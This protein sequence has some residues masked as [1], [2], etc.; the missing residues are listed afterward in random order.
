MQ[1]GSIIHSISIA[2]ITNPG[3]GGTG[4][5]RLETRRGDLNL[6]DY[7]HFFESVGID[8]SPGGINV[9]TVTRS[10]NDVNKI[11]NYIFSFQLAVKVPK[12]GA[13]TVEIEG[14]GILFGGI[15]SSNA[16]TKMSVDLT[17]K[18]IKFYVNDP[19]LYKK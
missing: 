9:F 4:N 14:D 18:K 16:A 3:K 10:E 12:D 19:Y 11:A 13:I 6:I 8:E 7:N 1:S 15:G 5:F 17:Q 2:G